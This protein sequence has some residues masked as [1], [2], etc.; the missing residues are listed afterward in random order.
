MGGFGGLGAGQKGNEHKNLGQP[1]EAIW[2]RDPRAIPIGGQKSKP[3]VEGHY[4]LL[5]ATGGSFQLAEQF[6]QLLGFLLNFVIGRHARVRLQ[7]AVKIKRD[8]SQKV[9]TQKLSVARPL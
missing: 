6:H 3:E 2:S 7:D 1:K 9:P 5:A 8:S 4:A